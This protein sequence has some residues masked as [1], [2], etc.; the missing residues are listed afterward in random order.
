MSE[1]AWNVETA[2][3]ALYAPQLTHYMRMGQQP[4]GV[5]GG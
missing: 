2:H 1:L 4:D 3:E 5:R